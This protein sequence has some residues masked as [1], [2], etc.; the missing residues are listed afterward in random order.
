MGRGQQ[1]GETDRKTRWQA[2]GPWGSSLSPQGLEE[3]PDMEVDPILGHQHNSWSG[4]RDPERIWC[5][6]KAEQG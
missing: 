1:I 5:Q 4:N 2:G 3:L 6:L